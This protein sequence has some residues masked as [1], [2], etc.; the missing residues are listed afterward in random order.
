LFKDVLLTV[1]MC[2]DIVIFFYKMRNIE[3]KIVFKCSISGNT[4][5][6]NKLEIP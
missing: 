4:I 3:V 1:L 5:V 6:M 2:T